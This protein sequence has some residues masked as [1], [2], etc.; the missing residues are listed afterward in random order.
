MPPDIVP[1]TGEDQRLQ[2]IEPGRSDPFASLPTRPFLVY[3]RPVASNS[4]TTTSMV[5][6]DA[7]VPAPPLV[8]TGQPSV[9][10]PPPQTVVPVPIA[11]QLPTPSLAQRQPSVPV[12][13]TSPIPIAVTA[14]PIT[15]SPTASESV[16]VA[17]A[18]PT[19][20]S[21]EFS[22]VVQL[23][24]RVNI[25]VEEPSGSRYVQIGER[26]GNGQF[27]IKAV[28]FNQGS[29]PAV[30]LERNGTESMYWVGHPIAL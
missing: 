10:P 23:G 18:V 6:T 15:A 30:I 11:S 3:Q 1:A 28:D 4:V 22:G 29:T 13:T 19:S 8:S 16:S 20:P 9:V 2:A 26:V 25:I 12:A 27:V 14:S 24:D 5:P 21:F 7:T 17:S